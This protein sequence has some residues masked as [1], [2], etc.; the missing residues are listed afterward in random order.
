MTTSPAKAAPF[1]GVL[2][3]L[4]LA[5]ACG[6]E[7]R[8]G[9]VNVGQIL[10]R[11]RRAQ[12]LEKSL[13]EEFGPKQEEFET[14]RKELARR[15]AE[16]RSEAGGEQDPARLREAKEIETEEFLLKLDLRQH[17]REVEAARDRAARRIADEIS[18]VCARIARADGYDLILKLNGPMAPVR[19][20]R[21]ALEAFQ[22]EGILYCSPGIDMTSRVLELLE[23]AY[24]RGIRLVPPG[25]EGG[26][27]APWKERG[28]APGPGWD[29][30]AKA[31]EAVSG[32][33]QEPRDDG[34]AD[35][36]RDRMEE[37]RAR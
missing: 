22:L 15:L 30:D 8:V 12:D 35:A 13:T 5:E 20:D 2:S 26:E 9:V 7:L 14:R 33:P 29:G 24:R 28:E 23:D 16:F 25:E 19:D 11:Y 34:L 1:A 18:A 27:D 36:G 3:L 10:A 21:G 17:G 31:A 4:C 6:A 32:A 37:A